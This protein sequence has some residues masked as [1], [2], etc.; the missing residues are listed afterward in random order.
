MWRALLSRPA[1]SQ[2]DEAR[3]DGWGSSS[4]A[5]ANGSGAISLPQPISLSMLGAHQ[6]Q[7]TSQG[8][9][10]EKM[11]QAILLLLANNNNNSSSNRTWGTEDGPSLFVSQKYYVSP[12]GGLLLTISDWNMCISKHLPPLKCCDRRGV[13][14]LRSSNPRERPT[15][16]G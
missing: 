11:A 14:L 1:F 16:P 7:E 4:S 9:G 10:P 6:A 13:S 3:K 5:T 8:L 12:A 2:Q 15:S